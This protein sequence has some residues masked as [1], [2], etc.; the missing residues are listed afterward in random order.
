VPR[1]PSAQQVSKTEGM[2]ARSAMDAALASLPARSAAASCVHVS[3]CPLA[4]SSHQGGEGAADPPAGHPPGAGWRRHGRYP[5]TEALWQRAFEAAFDLGPAVCRPIW[6]D[7]PPSS[8]QRL[9][10]VIVPDVLATIYSMEEPVPA[11]RLAESVWDTVEAHFDLDSLSPPGLMGLRGRVDNGVEHVFKAFEALEA[12]TSTYGEASEVFSADLDEETTMPFGVER[13][14]GGERAAE[15]RERL[16]A[17]GRLVSLTPL[18]TRAMRQRML[19]EGREAGLVGELAGATPAELL[20]VVAQHYTPT[21]GAEEIAIW[22]AAHGGSL[23]PLVQAIRDCPF[24]SRRVALVQTLANS[25]PGL[26]HVERSSALARGRKTADICRDYGRQPGRGA[27][28]VA[29]LADLFNLRAEDR[30]TRLLTPDPGEPEDPDEEGQGAQA[31]HGQRDDVGNL[32]DLPPAVGVQQHRPQRLA[33]ADGVDQVRELGVVRLGHAARAIHEAAGC[34]VA[35]STRIRRVWCSITASTNTRAPD[36]VIV[37]KK[38]HAKRA[39]AWE[40]RKPAH[41]VAE[42]PGAGSI[43][44]SCKISHTVEGATFTPST[45]SSR[46]TRRYPHVGFSRTRRRTRA[47]TGRT[48]RGLPGRLDPDQAACR[49]LI[50]QV[51]MPAQHRVGAYQQPHPA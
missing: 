5:R 21:T 43:L 50:D 36:R 18:G 29:G 4:R 31:E 46:C 33:L 23:D 24:V 42:R 15:L 47:W 48:V 7:E 27:R 35:P 34:V 28:L 9:Y 13:P 39:S 3:R 16:A 45:S 12:V 49:F 11:A 10:D 17:P 20:G 14:F 25:V 37:S 6:A 2:P 26:L 51:T 19:A 1:G 32:G 40:R 44:A 8:V 41:V 38:S 22:R 30:G